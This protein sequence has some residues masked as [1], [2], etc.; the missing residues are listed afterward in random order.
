MATG[1]SYATGCRRY[2]SGALPVPLYRLGRLIMVGEPLIGV[3]T[4]IGQTVVCVRVSS[5]DQKR[6]LDWQ[7][8][9]VTT[10]ATAQRLVVSRVVAG[11]GSALCGHR[12]MFL[13]LLRD[14]QVSAIVVEHRDRFACF[15]VEYVEAA[16]TRGVGVCWWSARQR[17]MTTWS[18]T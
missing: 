5:A 6:D 8:A 4:D 9:R 12:E 18:R 17:S 13:A 14:V 16:L 10:W 7:V 15:G 3:A 11:V 1:I 2:E